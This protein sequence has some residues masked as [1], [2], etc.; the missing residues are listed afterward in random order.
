MQLSVSLR[1]LIIVAW[2]MLLSMHLSWNQNL[3]FRLELNSFN[4]DSYLSLWLQRQ[5]EKEKKKKTTTTTKQ[6]THILLLSTRLSLRLKLAM[7]RL[8]LIKWL[9]IKPKTSISWFLP[10]FEIVVQDT[11]TAYCFPFS[12]HEKRLCKTWTS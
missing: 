10:Q 12:R 11:T 9:S 1:C 6:Q 2:W 5:K 3:R 4:K 8:H 7:Y